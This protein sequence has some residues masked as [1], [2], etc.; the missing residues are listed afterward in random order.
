[1]TTNKAP[2]HDNT[3]C[4][5]WH[6]C[7]RPECRDRFNARRRALRAGAIQ[8]SRTLVDAEPIRQH[9]EDLCDAGLTPNRIAALAGVAHTTIDL[10]I[11]PKPSVGRGRKRFTLGEIAERILA[12]KPVTPIGALRRIQALSAIGW[13]T[14]HIATHAGLSHRGL[15]AL[16][17]HKHLNLPT[18]QKITNVYA[19]LS[20]ANPIDAGIL[21]GHAQRARDRAQA[22]RWPT[23]YYWTQHPD[24][25]DDPH[26][27][28][29][30]GV[31][32]REIVAQDANWIMRAGADRAT[33][34]E[35]LGVHKSYLDHALRDFPEYA[36]E[37]A[38]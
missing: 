17:G 11:K 12:V 1:M 9:I 35:R 32:R 16:D 33:A 27:Q 4:I 21:P 23:P 2:H 6:N 28:P 30:Y 34:A 20:T 7:T 18:T 5:Q 15:I 10:F 37:T 29:L 19:Q 8:P 38:A 36:L 26:F 14:R 31:T 22:N 13:T 24:G 3:I 25:I